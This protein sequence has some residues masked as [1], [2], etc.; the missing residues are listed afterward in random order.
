MESFKEIQIHIF[1]KFLSRD[2]N[3]RSNFFSHEVVVKGPQ[4]RASCHCAAKGMWHRGQTTQ[5][6]LVTDRLSL[7]EVRL[8]VYVRIQP[9]VE[10]FDKPRLLVGVSKAWNLFFGCPAVQN[11]S[12]VDA[13][14]GV[15]IRCPWKALNYI[16]REKKLDVDAAGMFLTTYVLHSQFSFEAIT[17]CVKL[18]LGLPVRVHVWCHRD[19]TGRLSMAQV[20]PLSPVF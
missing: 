16:E 6:P 15:D 4:H 2:E 7:P 11:Q 1:W 14:R 18:V 20:F 12:S 9:E 10:S 8:R 5:S 3:L 13:I 17:G 19:E